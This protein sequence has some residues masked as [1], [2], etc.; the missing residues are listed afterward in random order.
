M[1]TMARSILAPKSQPISAAS[2]R[3][4]QIALS[5]LKIARSTSITLQRGGSVLVSVATEASSKEPA[6]PSANKGDA[7]SNPPTVVNSSGLSIQFP[8][9]PSTWSTWLIGAAV[10]LSVPLY[11]RI[12]RVEE[13]VEKAEEAAETALEA[14][15]KAA[16]EVGHLAADLAKTSS[17]G[18]LKEVALKVEGIAERIERDA[19]HAEEVLHKVEHIT[20]EIEELLEPIVE[21]AEAKEREGKQEKANRSTNNS[22]TH[23]SDL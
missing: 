8:D 10:F 18:K 16:E 6:E 3:R 9:T 5:P 13:V 23:N 19:E 17:N 22:E 14:I 4:F 11:R 7:K 12:K 15:D 2:N 20:E 1:A 21:R